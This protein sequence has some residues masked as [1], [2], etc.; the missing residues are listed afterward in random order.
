VRNRVYSYDEQEYLPIYDESVTERMPAF[1][2]LDLRVDKTWTF[3]Q[4]RL[5]GYLDILN[6]TNRRNV[7]LINYSFDWDQEIQVFGLPIVP[8]FGLR[9]E[10]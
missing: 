4:W 9:G 8:I 5:T 10:W 6:A 1:F 3:R 2:S 7:E